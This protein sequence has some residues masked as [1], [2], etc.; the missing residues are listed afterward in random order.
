MISNVLTATNSFRIPIRHPPLRLFQL[1]HKDMEK[2]DPGSLNR[3]RPQGL[4]VSNAGRRDGG[5]LQRVDRHQF[6]RVHEHID[7]SVHVR[8]RQIVQVEKVEKLAIV[9]QGVLSVGTS[10]GDNRAGILHPQL[11]N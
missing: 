11:E 6:K 2:F 1:V 9:V 10:I 5:G 4:V 7:Q 8:Y 3:V